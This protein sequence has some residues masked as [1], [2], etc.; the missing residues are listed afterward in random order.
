MST[1]AVIAEFIIIGLLAIATISFAIFACLNISNFEFLFKLKDFL[2]FITI[3]FIIISYF[4][5]VLINQLL[6]VNYRFLIKLLKRFLKIFRFARR[7]RK[8]DEIIK[9]IDNWLN[10]DETIKQSEI[11]F[12]ILENS[13][14]Q[15]VERIKYMMSLSRLFKGV[16]AILPLLG[17]TLA[18]WLIK[19]F[20]NWRV[21]FLAIFIC[22]TISLLSLLATIH[23]DKEY[24]R[25]KETAKKIIEQKI[26][27]SKNNP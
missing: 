1:T 6:F 8:I 4:L 5:G 24:R 26:Y 2:S 16:S 15:V 3:T 17:I 9:N 25:E 10:N 23:Q 7:V 27:Q 21:G 18:I 22:F 13:S 14:L 11:L 20:H 19:V 12:F